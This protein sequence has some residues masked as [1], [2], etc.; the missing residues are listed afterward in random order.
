MLKRGHFKIS[1]KAFPINPDIKIETNYLYTLMKNVVRKTR[2]QHLIHLQ[3]HQLLLLL[4]QM[5]IQ[6]HHHRLSRRKVHW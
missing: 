2:R 6:Q 4:M 3:Q 1:L 5:E